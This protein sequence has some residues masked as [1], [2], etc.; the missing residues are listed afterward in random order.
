MDKF[1]LA[2]DFVQ[3]TGK[4]IFLTGKAGTGKTTFL[5]S[6]SDRLF[7][8][9][10]VVAPTGVAAINAGGVTIH[11]FFQLP[12]GPLIPNIDGKSDGFGRNG[13]SNFKF[14]REKIRIIKGLDLLVIDEISMVRADLLDGIDEVLRKYKNRNLPFGGVQLLM[15]GDLFQ[16]AP[17]VR[18]DDNEILKNYYKTYFF[19]GSLALQKTDFVTVELTHIFRQKDEEFINLLNNIR[20][21]TDLTNTINILNNR[22]I[23]GFSPKDEDRYIILTTHNH[24]SDSINKK[25]INEIPGKFEN[26]T[27]EVK[28]DFPEFSYPSDYELKMKIGAQVMFVKNDSSYEKRFYNGKIGK[29]SGFDEKNIVVKCPEDEYEIDV[30]IAE[31]NNMKYEIDE[32]TKEIKEKTVGVFRQF[33]LKLA[34]AITIHKSQGLTFEKAV[35]DA[36]DAFAFGQVYVALSRCKSIEGLVLSTP[37]ES[38]G[39]IEDQSVTG[40]NDNIRNNQ[41]DSEK[42]ENAKQEFSKMLVLELFDFNTIS[43][44]FQYFLKQYRENYSSID[45]FEGIDY[46]NIF[47]LFK[48][49]ILNVSDKFHKQL[50]TLIQANNRD[51]YCEAVQIRV[52]QAAEYFM[53]KALLILWEELSVARVESDNKI[54]KKTMGDALV[55]L[56][57]EIK[58]KLSVLEISKTGFQLQTYLA[59]K[60]KASI[61]DNFTSKAVKKTMKPRA[62][63]SE[64]AELYTLLRNWRSEKVKKEKVP[65]YL[66]MHQKPL[67]DLVKFM[68]INL[69]DLGS[70]KGIGNKKVE[71]Y[72][73]EIITIIKTYIEK[74]NII[75]PEPEFN[76]VETPKKKSKIK[77]E[78]P[79]TKKLSLEMFRQGKKVSEIAKERGYALTTIYGH[80]SFLVG[81]GELS[82]TEIVESDKL[83]EIEAYFNSVDNK[84]LG[85]A[86]YAL[87]EKYSFEE[88]RLVAKHL[89]F[90]EKEGK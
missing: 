12:F 46:Q 64:H 4:N 20:N 6:L 18:E 3:F 26:F 39:I 31:W 80:L 84:L 43:Y 63:A 69:K 10:I 28:G 9:L 79:D 33:P 67:A 35:I 29:I 40:F 8:R 71:A 37:I 34:W 62:D 25:K 27:A 90:V 78:K 47:D 16:L 89:E 14:S 58:P 86:F 70:I 51:I 42:L 2:F 61:P 30:E 24:Q 81:K 85:P 38:K 57:D 52:K 5:R 19:F 21:S 68:P 49:E 87:E 13:K 54:V 45:H 59:V 44:R 32:E 22:Y 17:V 56:I 73:E 65:A 53:E 41:P 76:L 15:I 50:S 36:R 48:N 82:V 88:L 1:Q 55:R 77:L 74:N 66:V 11:S 83:S 72:G 75:L 23:P 7:K 60:A